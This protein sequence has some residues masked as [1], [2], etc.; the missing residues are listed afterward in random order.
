MASMARSAASCSAA[1]RL[2]PEG[3]L[4]GVATAVKLTPAVVAVYNFFAG[5]RKA[6]IVS[7]LSFLACTNSHVLAALILS[8]SS[9]IL[10]CFRFN[11]GSY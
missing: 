4:T 11:S 1:R 5:K 2:L 8:Y 10:A 6:G 9:F 3:W 7:F